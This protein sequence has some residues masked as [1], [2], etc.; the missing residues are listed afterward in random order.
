M[1]WRSVAS[2]ATVVIP[3]IGAFVVSCTNIAGTGLLLFMICWFLVLV[4]AVVSNF[5]LDY[6]ARSL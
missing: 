2:I 3:W 4:I 1:T 5:I 6:R